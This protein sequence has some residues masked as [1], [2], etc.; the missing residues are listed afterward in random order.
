M[1]YLILFT[2]FLASSVAAETCRMQE[3]S[4]MTS[5]RTVGQVVNLSKDMSH[6]QCRVRY[7]IS[8]DGTLHN[9]EWTQKGLYQEEI[10]CQIAIQNGTNDLLVQLPGK[11]QTETLVVCKETPA[12]KAVFKGYEGQENEFGPHPMKRGYLNIG[13]AS[14]CRFFQGWSANGYSERATGVICENNNNRWTVVDKFR[15]DRR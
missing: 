3:T 6:N 1:K 4:Q 10:L 9:V 11:F 13:H 12:V 2:A 14:N 8:V 7:Q 5:Q 15:V